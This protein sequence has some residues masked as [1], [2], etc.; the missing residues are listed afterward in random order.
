MVALIPLRKPE[1]GRGRFLF[2]SDSPTDAA[3]ATEGEGGR[4]SSSTMISGEG[5]RMFPFPL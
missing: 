4:L 1:S 5:G 2:T 3:D